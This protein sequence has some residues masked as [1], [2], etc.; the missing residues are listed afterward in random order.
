MAGKVAA[1]KQKPLSVLAA[2]IRRNGRLLIARR[3][4]GDRFEGLWEFPGGKLEPEEK[5]EECLAR[6]MKEEFGVEVRVGEFLGSVRYTS[7]SLSVELSAYAVIH[8]SGA[9]HLYDHDEVRWVSPDEC[10]SFALTEP[11]RILLDQLAAAGIFQ[12]SR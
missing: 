12:E 11:D 6:E 4:K 8:I 2:I 10:R 7:S 3:K 9:L 5:P 1:G